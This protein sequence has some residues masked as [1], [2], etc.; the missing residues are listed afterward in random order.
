MTRRRWGLVLLSVA[1][2]AYALGQEWL[3]IRYEIIENHLLDVF[4]GISAAVAGIVALDRRP[5]N[6]I[7]WLL[8]G[9]A[10]AWHADPYVLLDL[11]GVTVI[12]TLIGGLHVALIGHLV[13]A[14]PTGRVQT[15]LERV[16][17]IVFYSTNLSLALVEMAVFDPR[18]W[19][20]AQCIWRP[21]IWPSEHAHELIMTV[22]GYLTT[23]EVL[24]FFVAVGLRF[25]RSSQVE[26]HNLMPLWVGALLLG[27]IEIL[28]TTGDPYAGGFLFLVWQIRSV[29][30]ILVPLVFLYGLLTDRTAKTAIGDLV[31]RLEGDIPTGQLG[32]ILADA[33]GD[34][35]LRIVYAATTGDGW[36]TAEGQPA[37]DPADQE[38]RHH[39]VTVIERDHRPYAA[40]IHDRALSPTLVSGVASAAALAI[41]N[42]WLHAELKAQLEEVRASRIRI[43][44]AGDAER[45]RVER[46][47]HDGAQQRLLAL[48]LAL[49]VARR[50][51]AN[52]TE[53]V[54]DDAMDRAEAELR[55]AID[56][57]RELARGIHPA[58]LTDDGLEAAVRALA[59]RSTVPV[60]VVFDLPGRLPPTIEATA[61]F[62]ISEALA[63]VSKHADATQ[64]VVRAAVVDALLRVDVRDDGCGGADCVRG[65]GLRGLRD[66]VAAIGGELAVTSPAGGGTTVAIRVPVPVGSLP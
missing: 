58:I 60:S 56:E 64:V 28:G 32:P 4:V 10:V 49:R 11:P 45:R 43:V 19:G 12:A 61:Y 37:G 62:A 9:I 59:A 21:A 47:L 16:L 18:A 8:V 17:V 44:A 53:P 7:G 65:S 50:Q 26:R 34:P 51:L 48:A 41:E 13:L 25:G 40:L 31:L 30:L 38:D 6:P 14:Y 24:L 27:L 20:C 5:G 35:A 36:V 52:G 29:L 55:L 15:R 66:R 54:V 39:Q 33:L 63:N 46:N 2:L 22:G 57:L 3:S 42:E 23:A 1:F